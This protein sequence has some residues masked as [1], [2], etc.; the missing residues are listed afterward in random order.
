M[1]KMKKKII[2][3]L[4]SCLSFFFLSCE[5]NIE[6]ATSK[7]VY[8]ESEN[9]YLKADAGATITNDI[10]FEVGRF[11]PQIINLEDYA[12]K[13]QEKM[14]MT[15][16][17]VII[18]LNNGSVVFY[19]ISTTRG[20]WD[21]TN[22][23]KGT[24]GWYYNSAGGVSTESDF[25]SSL[26]FDKNTKQLILDVNENA[27]AGTTLSF[28]VGFA[29]NGPDYDDYV[30]FA[31]N[32]AIT[33][34]SLIITSVSIPEGD[35]AAAPIDFNQYADV[36]QYNMGLNVEEFLNSLDANEGGTIR[37]YIINTETKEWD[38]TSDYTAAPPGYWI[39]DE[40]AVCNWNDDGF[41]LYAETNI[42]DQV[43]NIG[44][45]PALS[46]GTTFKISLGYKDT[47][48]E[49]SFIRFIITATLE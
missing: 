11:A 20:H 8:S 36:I 48:D 23:T 19:N 18:G 2:Y 45:A 34:P 13:F 38:I 33:D 43:L 37:M 41:S 9:P 25:I 24:T 28:N 47:E 15:V 22:E 35:Y 7:H 40:G 5:D 44:R 32:V 16:D 31:F 10:E 27:E 4:V 46:A 17:E 49:L 39:N 26:D 29:V 42:G 6:D 12:E 14:N 30:R 1:I 21:K 3:I